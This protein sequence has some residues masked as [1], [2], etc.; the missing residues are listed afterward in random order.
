MPSSAESCFPLWSLIPFVLIL[1]SIAILPAIV[2]HWWKSD[3][4]KAILSIIA[5]VPVLAIVLPCRPSLLW[6]SLLDY[7]S[8]LT[9]LTSLFVIAGGIYIKGEYAG[10]PLVNTMFLG[11]G[12][13]LANLIG[14]PGASM[15]LT[16]RSSLP[17]LFKSA[18]AAP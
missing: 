3:R 11:L 17:S 8:F 7:F 15:L 16:T 10:T 1:V 2:P 6:H 14:T 5:S 18:Y 12:A 13:L 4:N 9:L